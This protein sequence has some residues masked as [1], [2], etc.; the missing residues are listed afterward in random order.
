MNIVLVGYRCSGKSAVGKMLAKRLDKGFV[1]T[2]A[3]IEETEG[4]AIE[5][6]VEKKGWD[7][8]RQVEKKIVETVSSKD[9]LVIA[10]GGGVVLYESNIKNL[11]EN[12]TVIWLKADVNILKQ[13]MDKDLNSGQIRPS[14]TGEDPVEEIRKVLKIRNP[15]YQRAGDLEVDTGSSTIQEVADMIIDNIDPQITQIHTD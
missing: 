9:N 4:S 5:S 13:R 6:M 3:L 12:G 2:D 14:L 7:Y 8:F 10:T 11:K 1:D 15:L